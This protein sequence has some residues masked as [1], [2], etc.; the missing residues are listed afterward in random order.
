MKDTSTPSILEV[1]KKAK[2]R[3]VSKADELLI[4]DA[5]LETVPQ[6]NMAILDSVQQLLETIKFFFLLNNDRSRLI[7]TDL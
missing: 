4:I 6:N 2:H 5:V 3:V 7:L 1:T